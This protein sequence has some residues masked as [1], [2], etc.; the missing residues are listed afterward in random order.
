MLKRVL[1]LTL[2]LL[3]TISFVGCGNAASKTQS[4]HPDNWDVEAEVLRFCNGFYRAKTVQDAQTYLVSGTSKGSVKAYLNSM[5]GLF[6]E[7]SLDYRDYPYDSVEVTFLET[8]NGYEI[9]WVI[10]SSTAILQANEEMLASSGIASYTQLSP[11]LVALTIEKGH[12]VTSLD[13]N[14]S[15]KI[16]SKYDYCLSC[17][18]LGGTT[19]PGMACPDCGGLGQQTVCVCQD[20]AEEFT[21]L[22]SFGGMKLTPIGPAEEEGTTYEFNSALSSDIALVDRFADSACPSCNGTNIITEISFCESCQGIS[23]S[24]AGFDPCTACDGKGWI[25]K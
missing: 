8:Y 23:S 12:Y 16:L 5:E 13:E 1:A 21:P 11:M 24:E 9:F 17:H 4:Q 3:L 14:L 7:G 25:K 15:K 20:C 2:A 6:Q 10:P 18:G 19:M 22:L